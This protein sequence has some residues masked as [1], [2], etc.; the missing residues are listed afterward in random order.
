MTPG[1]SSAAP[2]AIGRVRSSLVAYSIGKAITA[3]LS[4]LLVLLLAALMPREQYAAYVSAVALLEIGVVLG[5]FGVEWVMQTALA[6]IQV[7]GNAAQ[8]RRAVLRLGALPCLTYAAAGGLLWAV[9]DHVSAWLGG[10]APAAV[11]QLAGILLV[12]EGPARVLRDSLMAVL[13]L[14]RIAQ[15]S[16]VVRVVGTCTGVYLSVAWLA[17]GEPLQAATVLRIEIA[18]AAVALI[19][20]MVGLGW[21]LR[22]RTSG[23]DPS[24]GAWVG[25]PSA[26]FAVHAYLS[27][28]LM[29]LIGTD[30]MTTLVAR[31]LGVEA[32]ASFGFVVRLLETARRYLPM[33][34][35]WGVVR[36]AAIGRFESGGR[37]ARKLMED[38]NRMIDANLI[39]VAGV[40]TVSLVAGDALV[41][42]LSRGKVHDG[43]WLLVCLV[44][45]LAGHT[46]R[47][48]TELM[49]YTLSHSARF[50]RAAIACLLAVPLSVLLLTHTGVPHG[51]PAA[52]LITDV[53]FI[54][55]AVHG[56]RALGDPVQ[57]SLVRWKRLIWVVA[58]ASAAGWAVRGLCTGT[59]SAA[60]PWLEGMPWFMHALDL[61]AQ[62]LIAAGL[63][64]L[65]ACAAFVAAL[66]GLRVI[67][68]GESLLIRL[69][70]DPQEPP[71]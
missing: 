12:L 36:P 64:A 6:A 22:G 47:R 11:L 30:V 60:T 1:S 5:T 44:P 35:F 50:A 62:P 16:Q 18:V 41:Q 57:F 28:V 54:A 65:T 24:I 38:C 70:P 27:I 7:R 66:Q 31:H 68:P 45:L 13:L 58:L 26:R 43:G 67:A 10:V 32:T 4:L 71:S 69:Q 52:V 42:L 37:D 3:P 17:P 21:H 53:V 55:A 39:A 61:L 56:L 59:G 29:L 40:L 63:G 2:Y 46:V 48:G 19:V 33:D 34:L 20:A 15:V 8:L 14:Q 9:A 51:A 23:Q 49:A 25:W